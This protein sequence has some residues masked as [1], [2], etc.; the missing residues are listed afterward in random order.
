VGE[1]NM[2]I[3]EAEMATASGDYRA[4][5]TR[6]WAI[7][8]T[9]L[10]GTTLAILDSSVLNLLVVPVM[11]EFRADLRTVE[12]VLTSYN[13]TFAVF[14]IGLGSLGD[15]AGRRRLYVFGQV[16]FVLGSGLAAVASGPWQ[17]VAFRAIQGVGAAALAPN[18]LALI[19]DHFPEG[20]RGAALGIWGAAAG[21]GGAL[22]PT[23]GGLVAQG[24]GWRALFLINVPI[25]LFVA[26]AA[27]GLLSA[28]LQP[29]GQRF[30][31]RG[32]VALSGALLALS[33]SLM[34]VPG[35][36]GT[37]AKGGFVIVALL[38]GLWFV[39]VE[40]RAP[41]P[42]VDLRAILRLRVIATNLVVFFALL[43]MAGGMF[44]SVLYAQLLTE[45]SPASIGLLLAPCASMT[46]A[47]A[48]AGGWLADK[49]G[50]R[51]LAV[52][53]LLALT[54]SVA[55]P[56]QWHPASAAS[57]VFW[58]NLIAGIGIGVAT[59]ALIRVATEG[60]GQE[61]AGLG[62]GIYKTVNELGGVF[63]V[64][65]LGT[66]LEGRI[67]ANALRQI[68]DHFLPQE[69]S[70]KTVTSLKI[71][72]SHALQKGLLIQDLDGFHRALIDAIRQ[73]FDQVFGLAALLAGIG[74]VVALMVPRRLEN[75]AGEVVVRE[76]P[77]R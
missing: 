35:L 2:N 73:G 3:K 9:M 39:R 34:E 58:S 18:A 12:W 64:V 41:M 55:I 31:T 38:L 60:V 59:P 40:Q 8:A 63:G 46:F 48:P 10:V 43:I 6:R 17:L 25:G 26:G 52:A 1:N 23:V 51:I 70:L 54:A 22:G 14:M 75:A 16:V 36:G 53:G 20:E 33:L 29:R 21:L 13:L 32:F 11:E 67:V 5:R 45:A 4:G 37:V 65:L 72:E 71:L 42:L 30:D 24:W 68:P 66:L 7:L 74:V 69:L 27:Y 47:I 50:P 44:L 61:R 15:T 57:L 19:L 77:S 28:D 62:A 56:I 49:I 76:T